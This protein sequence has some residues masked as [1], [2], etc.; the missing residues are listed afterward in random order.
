MRL[1]DKNIIITG[2]ASGIGLATAER[3]LQEGANVVMADLPTCSHGEQPR[4]LDARACRESVF[5][6]RRMSTSTAQ[7]DALI[8]AT[9][10][11]LG[12]VD[13]VFNNAGIGG[14]SPA[15]TYTDEEF[16]RVIDINLMGVFWIA[17]LPCVR[18]ISRAVAASLIA[19]R[20]SVCSVRA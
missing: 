18:C 7:A 14:M 16:L 20:Y 6:S 13:G 4:D 19:H 1:K 3:C 10:A 11:A 5:L 9:V 15:D 8:A 17:A 2:G 12:S